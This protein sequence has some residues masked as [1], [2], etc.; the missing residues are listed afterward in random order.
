MAKLEYFPWYNS[1]RERLAKLSDQEVGWLVRTLSKYNETG[2]RQEL[3]GRESV[4]FD[5]IAVDIDR[6]KEAYRKKCETNKRNRQ[7]P[8]PGFNEY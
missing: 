7:A 3:A 8:I 6:A 4:A 2:E 5:F 1:Y